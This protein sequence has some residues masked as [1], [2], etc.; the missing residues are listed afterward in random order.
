MCQKKK[1]TSDVDDDDFRHHECY[2]KFLLCSFFISVSWRWSDWQWHFR[3]SIE[4]EIIS[5]QKSNQTRTSRS[6][7]LIP[8]IEQGGS[9]FSSWGALTCKSSSNFLRSQ[10]KCWPIFQILSNLETRVHHILVFSPRR[11]H[12]DF[13]LARR[14]ISRFS[15]FGM[16]VMSKSSIPMT[17]TCLHDFLKSKFLHLRIGIEKDVSL[18]CL[19]GLTSVCNSKMRLKITFDKWILQ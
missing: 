6:S 19:Y 8:S 7:P 9:S 18:L 15:H 12:F 16:F 4:H 3:M 10:F 11:F 13:F 17:G 2:K 5:C 1:R 14:N